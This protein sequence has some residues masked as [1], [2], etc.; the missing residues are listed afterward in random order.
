MN[1]TIPSTVNNADKTTDHFVV[2]YGRGYDEENNQYYYNYIET[3]RSKAS[4]DNAYENQWILYYDSNNK[5]FKGKSY[6][7]NKDY[8][9]VQIRPN[10]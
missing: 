5:S 10:F 8:E 4:E 6:R 2:I 1:H 7:K 9:I 3:G